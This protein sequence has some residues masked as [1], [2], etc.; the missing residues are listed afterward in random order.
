M[1]LN[2]VWL[3][4]I[5]LVCECVA[6]RGVVLDYLANKCSANLSCR[7]NHWAGPSWQMRIRNSYRYP[8]YSG[9]SCEGHYHLSVYSSA[10]NKNKENNKVGARKVK[11]IC[12]SL[13][14]KRVPSSQTNGWSRSSGY[15]SIVSRWFLS[16]EQA[17]SE[18]GKVSVSTGQRSL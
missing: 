16:Y 4:R 5:V 18:D 12:H 14:I 9:D 17:L 11:M 8:P 3:S 13:I 6:S 2:R 15:K 7:V 10:V 1:R